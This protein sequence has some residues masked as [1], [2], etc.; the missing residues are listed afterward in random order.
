[1]NIHS[2]IIYNS[3]KMETKVHQLMNGYIKC[4]SHMMLQYTAIK[5]NE[6]LIHATIWINRNEILIH[7]TIWINLENT[8]LSERSQSQSTRGYIITLM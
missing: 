8:T 1:M 2:S 4:D 5:R 3:Q 7:A 6:I